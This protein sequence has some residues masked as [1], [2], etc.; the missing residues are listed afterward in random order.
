[1]EVETF[2]NM[3]K[4]CL[5]ITIFLKKIVK[6]KTWQG[7]DVK[8]KSNIQTEDC[9]FYWGITSE[10]GIRSSFHMDFW[11]NIDSV[12]NALSMK[13]LTSVIF[14]TKRGRTC[15]DNTGVTDTSAIGSA[16]HVTSHAGDRSHDPL[17]HHPPQLLTS[18]VLLSDLTCRPPPPLLLLY[19]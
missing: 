1:M 4:F 13:K 9:L 6:K 18:S 5:H 16:Y 15:T 3:V 2:N 17:P 11:K 12:K 19:W 7:S 10:E 8:T 14:P